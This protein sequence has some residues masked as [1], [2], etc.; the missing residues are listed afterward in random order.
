MPPSRLKSQLVSPT[1]EETLLALFVSGASNEI[2]L[3]FI[4]ELTAGTRPQKVWDLWMIRYVRKELEKEKWIR[5]EVKE[6]WELRV[7][8]G[9]G[10]S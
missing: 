1:E 5:F 4:R 10:K 8:S 3:E 7:G 2:A 6:D 9:S